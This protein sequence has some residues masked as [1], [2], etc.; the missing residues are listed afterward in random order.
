MFKSVFYSKIHAKNMFGHFLAWIPDSRHFQ[1]VLGR[2][3]H[4]ESEFEVKNNKFRRP[5]GKSL[6]KRIQFGAGSNEDI[7]HRI[8]I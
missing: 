8:R 5:E 1:P 3:F 7:S 6:E 4:I 2:T